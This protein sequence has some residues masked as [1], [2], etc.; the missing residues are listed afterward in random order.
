V[1]YHLLHHLYRSCD[2][3]VSPA[4]TETFA[5]P[6]VEAMSSGLPVVA[7]D[8]PVHRE[9]CQDA[10]TYFPRFSPAILAEQVL[11]IHQSPELAETLSRNGLKRAQDFRW[12]AHV[13]SLLALA[14][15]LLIANPARI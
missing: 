11:Q 1:P 8:L 3:Y 14:Q 13:D 12:D 9:I 7:S 5:H 4:Y 10:A 2:I 6:L 15:K